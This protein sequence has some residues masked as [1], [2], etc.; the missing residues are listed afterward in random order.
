M[1][2]FT[3]IDFLDTVRAGMALAT[4]KRVNMIAEETNE[5]TFLTLNFQTKHSEIISNMYN[6]GRLHRNIK[7]R[8]FYQDYY[9][10]EVSNKSHLELQENS[11]QEEGCYFYK[12]ERPNSNGYRYYD[13]DGN[14]L[15]YK[16]FDE[17]LNLLFIDY[18]S[19]NMQRTH[20]VEYNA[21]GK[22]VREIRYNLSTNKPTLEKYYD[23]NGDCF[24]SIWINSQGGR[25]KCFLHRENKSFSTINQMYSF[26]V[27]KQLIDEPSPTLMLDE[28]NLLP[29]FRDVNIPCF[30]VITLHS[31]HLEKPY[32]KGAP[33]R[34]VYKEIFDNSDEFD[35]VVFLTP[36]QK[37]DVE[38]VYGK[39]DNFH[40]IPHSVSIDQATNFKEVVSRNSKSIITLGRLEEN[41]NISDGIKAFKIVV[42]R[43]NDAEYHIY[44]Y[45]KE[46]ENLQNLINEL[47]LE[48]NVFIHDF[49]HDVNKE[50]QR[51]ACSLVTSKYE[52]FCLVIMESLANKTPVISY[53]TKYGPEL[54]IRHGVDGCLVEYGNYERVASH[55][56]EL[57]QDTEK[58]KLYSSNALDIYNRFSYKLYKERWISLISTTPA[59]TGLFHK[60][61]R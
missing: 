44:G 1:T 8:N 57:M 14:Y 15:K 9:S 32:T 31:T 7:V 11:L 49:I 20:K 27:E 4:E 18:Q 16:S 39:K 26:W 12:D 17:F 28:L 30:K 33:M 38:E 43:I 2:N 36:E 29:I 23:I 41:K 19:E 53:N 59:K 60:F 52:A 37:N 6:M 51:H 45:G 55:I 13:L 50:L 21:E 40:V 25:T 24:L 56:I 35:A 61:F 58:Q 46:K 3:L 34:R 47:N 42:D 22:K 5:A 10:C 54:L 48:N